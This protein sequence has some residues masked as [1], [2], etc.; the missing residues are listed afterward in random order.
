MDLLYGLLGQLPWWG[1]V[2]ML[3]VLTHFTI[4]SVTLY[5]HR[6]KTHGSVEFNPI[7]E[8]F[9]RFWLWLTTGMKTHEWVAV[10]RKHHDKCETE[11]DPHSPMF[12]KIA[13]LFIYAIPIYRRAL[14]QE[15][16]FAYVEGEFS[17]GLPDD[18]IEHNVYTKYPWLG[19]A[20]LGVL[21]TVILGWPGLFM[22]LIQAYWIPGWAM[23]VINGLGHYCG[24]RSYNTPDE[25]HNIFPWGILIGGE[26]LHNNHHA[27]QTSAKFSQRWFE[28]DIGWVVIL[29]LRFLRLAK[30]KQVTYFPVINPE[31]YWPNKEKRL[32]I[33]IHHRSWIAKWFQEVVVL[34]KAFPSADDEIKLIE[35][36]WDYVDPYGNFLPTKEGLDEWCWKVRRLTNNPKLLEFANEL[37]S[38][39]EREDVYPKLR[40][41]ST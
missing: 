29:L 5:L 20:I 16:I 33:F 36:F 7:I 6:S 2:V 11:E 38:L 4:I 41:I 19:L 27:Y 18:W 21:E 35:E 23:G 24:Y 40:L 31:M 39:H 22:F 10:H 32:S 1:Y 26:E 15:G 30:I 14:K 9:F 37:C 34:G 28:F 13:H 25:S 8:H 17:K 3:L 12:H